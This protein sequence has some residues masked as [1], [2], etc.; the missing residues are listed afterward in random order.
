MVSDRGLQ[1]AAGLTKKL[2]RMLGIKTKLSIAFHSQTDRQTEHIN[3]KLEQYLQFFV[4]HR[5]KNWPEQLALA[6]FA[7]NNK[8]HSTTK[9]SPFMANYSRELRMEGEIRKKGKVEKATEFV[10]KLKRVQE[11]VGAALK[12]MQKE[13]KKYADQNRKEIEKQK[14][15]N[16]VMLISQIRYSLVVILELNGGSEVQYKDMMMIDDGKYQ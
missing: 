10:E 9:V 4:N 7:V 8:V 12:R 15:G 13:M 6:E 5:Q 11:E 1:F 14:K 2:N 16:R 3:Q